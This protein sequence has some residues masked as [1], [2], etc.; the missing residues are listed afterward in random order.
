M[1]PEDTYSLLDL[2]SIAELPSVTVPHAV[3]VV[4]PRDKDK[5]RQAA[6]AAAIKGQLAANGLTRYDSPS[7]HGIP[8]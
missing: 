8:I 2:D 3:G 5:E 4:A 1:N 7:R 6:V